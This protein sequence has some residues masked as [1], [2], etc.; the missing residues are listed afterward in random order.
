MS[1]PFVFAFRFHAPNFSGTE[2]L[3]RYTLRL[4]TSQQFQKQNNLSL[5]ANADLGAIGI[6]E[7]TNS[8]KGFLSRSM[9]WRGPNTK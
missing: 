6:D 3:M 7:I 8:E 1:P 4:L 9:G 2:I 5:R